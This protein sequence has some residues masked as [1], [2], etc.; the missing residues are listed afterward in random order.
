M[1]AQS[2][3]IMLLLANIANLVI[4]PE[5]SASQATISRRSMAPSLCESVCS[6]WR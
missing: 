4:A 6:P 3:A 1:R 2:T 5:W